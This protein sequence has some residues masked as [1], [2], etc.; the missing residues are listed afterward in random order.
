MIEEN[1]I[2]LSIKT[3]LDPLTTG[4]E[5]EHF[6]NFANQQAWMT[7]LDIRR[8]KRMTDLI[9]VSDT[10]AQKE[11]SVNWLALLGTAAK[12][13]LNIQTAEGHIQKISLFL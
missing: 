9:T 1:I 6:V 10:L 5:P 8:Q 12:E 3:E 4:L 7:M 13:C 2:G 11:P